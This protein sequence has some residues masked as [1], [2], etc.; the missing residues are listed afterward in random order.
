[1]K[2]ERESTTEHTITKVDLIC[3]EILFD[4]LNEEYTPDMFEV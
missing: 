2:R 4:V 3:V 1:M